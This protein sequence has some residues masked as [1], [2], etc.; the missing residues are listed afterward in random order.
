MIPLPEKKG[1]K[2][3]KILRNENHTISPMLERKLRQEQNLIFTESQI[4]PQV[5]RLLKI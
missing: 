1:L 4:G 2:W 3:G 5:M